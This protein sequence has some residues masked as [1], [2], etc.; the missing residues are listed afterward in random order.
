[1]K[2]IPYTISIILII[3]IFTIISCEQLS[4]KTADDFATPNPN[5]TTGGPTPTPEPTV[6]TYYNDITVYTEVRTQATIGSAL[7]WRRVA[8]TPRHSYRI[9]WEDESKLDNPGDVVLSIYGEDLTPYIKNESFGHTLTERVI[10]VK[11]GDDYLYINIE[12]ISGESAGFFFFQIVLESEPIL[13]VDT[14]Y[15]ADEMLDS[16][17][18]VEVWYKVHAIPGYTYTINW[19][20]YQNHSE[21]ENYSLDI[22]VSAY[23][24]DKITAYFENANYGYLPGTDIAIPSG[25]N[26]FYIKVTKYYHFS[27]GT[28][29]IAVSMPTPPPTLSVNTGYSTGEIISYTPQWYRVNVIPGDSYTIKWQDKN[30]YD[31]NNTTAYTVS[32]KVGVFRVDQETSYFED[33]TMGYSSDHEITVVSDESYIYVKVESLIY[34]QAGTYAV[35]VYDRA[36]YQPT[37]IPTIVPDTGYLSGEITQTGQAVWYRVEGITGT[38]YNVKWQDSLDFDPNISTSYTLN[39]KVSI[40]M[41]DQLTAYTL[42]M[43][44]GY[45]ADHF[46]TIVNGQ[47]SFYIKVEPYNTGT[48]GTYAIAV[49]EQTAQQTTPTP[50]IVPDTGYLNGEIT[51]PDQVVWYRVDGTAGYSYNVKW[52]DS[53]EFDTNSSTSYSL[54]IKVSICR[55]DQIT[56]YFESQDSGYTGDHELTIPNTES[57]FYIIIEAFNT[58]NTGTY[59]VAVNTLSTTP[60]ITVDDPSLTADLSADNEEDWYEATVLSDSIYNIKW[61][62]LDLDNSL[63]DL[64]VSVYREDMTTPYFEN[65]DAWSLTAGTITVATGESKIYI[66]AK[67]LNSTARG[68]YKIGV[69][70]VGPQGYIDLTVGDASYD[71]TITQ[72]EDVWFKANVTPGTQYRLHWIDNYSSSLYSGTVS[73]S[74]YHSDFTTTYFS[75][76]TDI[77][78]TYEDLT[79]DT[80]ESVVYF[81][82]TGITG[83]TFSIRYNLTFDPNGS[84]TNYSIAQQTQTTVQL[85]W[86]VYQGALSYTITIY[87]AANQ[88]IGGYSTDTNLIDITGLNTGTQYNFQLTAERP[89]LSTSLQ[90]LTTTL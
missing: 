16:D 68:T 87:D 33:G 65:S 10:K 15:Y 46:M 30:D 70:Y 83:G 39:V 74:A 42:D 11:P 18:E 88:Y 8:V 17:Q 32:T 66:K 3:L 64:T 34:G 58:G 57:S 90:T 73:V 37:P 82:V 71:G 20:D 40:F 76:K 1:M 31:T 5:L 25:E 59:A 50:T 47:S 48:I 72:N 78:H 49:F 36:G 86:D 9:K 2:K 43:D 41:E 27:Q 60:S 23:Q 29:A 21:Y 69:F 54:D 7:S 63:V 14:G 84:I 81:K 53:Y 85:T 52:Q 19:Q 28:Y 13:S 24:M 51:Q 61:D 12:R 44:A 79:A 75:D 35:A 56:A 38:E 4:F 22:E 80:S 6:P 67:G 55:A 45:S 26:Y 77:S 62:D 89:P